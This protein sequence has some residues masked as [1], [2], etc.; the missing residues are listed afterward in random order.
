M[1][2]QFDWLSALGL[3]FSITNSWIGYL[4]CFGQNLTYGGAQA[5]IFSLIVAFAIQFL[6]TIGLAGL[7]SAYPVQILIHSTV[8]I[9]EHL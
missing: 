9:A 2:R 7:G 8:T 1:P 5:C 6:V 3:G 4:S